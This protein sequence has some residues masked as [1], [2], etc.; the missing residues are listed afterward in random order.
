MSRVIRLTQGKV[1]IVDD[2]DFERLSGQRWHAYRYVRRMPNYWFAIGWHEGKKV[3]MHRF[4]LNLPAGQ[5]GGGIQVDHKN[6]NALDNRRSNLRLVTPQQNVQNQGRNRVNKTGF[7]GVYF[8][9]ATKK[10]KAAIRVNGKKKHLG[11]FTDLELAGKAYQIAAKQYF[12]EF[13]RW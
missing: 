7:K 2:A 3:R 1:A 13:A 12:G 4:I 6:G 8:C 5:R 11:C 9:N 10:F